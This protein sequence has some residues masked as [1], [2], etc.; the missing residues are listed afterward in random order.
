MTLSVSRLEEKGL[1]KA[2]LEYF[3][4]G[5]TRE[6]ARF[7]AFFGGKPIF[8]GK[9]VLDLG[10]GFGS[11]TIDIAESGAN[12][13]L[14]FDIDVE[15]IDFATNILK[16]Y[17]PY[18]CDRV[19]FLNVDARKYPFSQYDYIISK[20]SFEHII[21][22]EPTLSEM[23][24]RLKEGGRIYATVSTWNGPIG[25]H[26]L[27]KKIFHM[28]IPWAHVLLG[29]KLILR[30]LNRK[31]KTAMNSINELGFNMLS[32]AEYKRIFSQLGLTVVYFRTNVAT[33]LHLH[34]R[35]LLK[36]LS[37]CGRVPMLTEFSC[38]NFCIILEK[39]NGLLETKRRQQSLKNLH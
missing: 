7:W 18:L 3:D 39:S 16:I 30:R 15:R 26:G 5:R 38:S 27:I 21:S 8:K 13:V 32:L 25:D 22:L 4:R 33:G 23:A 14:G 19:K 1:T 6:N 29:E 11:L 28:H 12:K 10:C 20:D 17:Y 2:N 31:L 36:I 34:E 24:K 37:A 9:S 35:S